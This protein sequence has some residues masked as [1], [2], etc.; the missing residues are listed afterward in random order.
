MGQEHIGTAREIVAEFL[1]ELSGQPQQMFNIAPGSVPTGK[2]IL[3][4]PRENQVDVLLEAISLQIDNING[5]RAIISGTK[6]LVHSYGLKALLSAL[7]RRRLPFNEEQLVSVVKTITEANQYYSWQF[8]LLGVLHAVD[9]F[10]AER[11]LTEPLRAALTGLTSRLDGAQDYA[12]IRKV[13][14]RLQALLE[15][16]AGDTSSPNLASGEPWTARLSLAL[17]QMEAAHRQ[18]WNALLTHCTS[19]TSAKPS[20]KWL[21][22]GRQLLKAIGPESFAAVVAETLAEVGK[23]GAPHKVCIGGMEFETDPTVVHQSH[24]DLLRGLVW[25]TS[26]GASD[27][28]I[29]AVG[30]TAEVCFKKIPGFGP[31]SPK[32]GNACLWALA[33]INSM[34]AV[35]QLSRL[36]TRAK[37]ASTRKQL[38]KALDAAAEN[39]GMAAEELEEIAVPTCGLTAV[40]E[41]RKPIGD[42][43]GILRV[44]GLKAELSW[45]KADGKA[46]ASVPATIKEAHAADLKALKQAVKEIDN[47]LPAQRDRMEQLCLQERSWSFADFRARFLDQPLV[48]SLARRLIWRFTAGSESSDGI[49][50]DG[51]IVDESDRP[52]SWLGEQSRVGVWHPASCPVARVEAWRQ[53]LERHQVRQPFKQAHREIYVLTDA[54]RATA[55]YSNRFAAHIIKQH[56]FAAL[57]LQR[58]WRYT[59]Q[60]QWDS[61]NTPFR[62]LPQWDLRV[63]FWV[64]PIPMDDA[65]ASGVY[66]YLSTDQVRFYRLGDNDPLPLDR[67]PPLVFSELMRDVDLFVGVA[68]VGNDANW[69]DGGPHGRYREYW[70]SFAFSE[71]LSASAQTRKTVLE[72]LVPRLKIAGQCS[73]T[74]RFL[75]VKGRLRSYKIHLGSGNILMSPNDQ[76]LCIVPKQGASLESD[77]KLFLPFEGDTLLSVILSKALLLADDTRIKDPLILSQIKAR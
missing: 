26:L 46:Q 31:R 10:A 51:Q 54:E 19:A 27:A 3:E 71:E 8:S 69:A 42:F 67:V 73:F 57:C 40:G 47:L 29:V 13:R 63:E 18:P 38:G 72:R 9:E 5:K 65:A 16:K 75:V 41:L 60:G 62:D 48:G 28:L 74:D 21:E 14:Q 64:Q 22:Q 20:K 50:L 35:A 15:A 76:Y 43:T 53:W 44:G 2:A 39:T 37:H 59:L 24:S 61:H 55:T 70:Q 68:S 4:L 45:L 7:L 52:L 17:S 56:Q 25:C 11:G 36:K 12:E 32:I 30:D 33:A 66:L 77:G 58:G 34:A 1:R 6:G 49:W 23:P